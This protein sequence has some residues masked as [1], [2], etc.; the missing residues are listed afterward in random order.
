MG[1]DSVCFV[2]PSLAQK[3][4]V[5]VEPALRPAGIVVTGEASAM[6]SGP[7]ASGPVPLLQPG[8]IGGVPVDQ[9]S[10]VRFSSRIMSLYEPPAGRPDAPNVSGVD[11]VPF[12]LSSRY[13][14]PP[15]VV[16]QAGLAVY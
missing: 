14:V 9:T 8:G 4:M 5:S 3:V 6:V 12:R 1:T 15:A 13:S 11:Q 2:V 16:K 10:L 7:T